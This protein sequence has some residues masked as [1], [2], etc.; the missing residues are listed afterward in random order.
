VGPRAGMDAV[1]TRRN[2]LWLLEFAILAVQAVASRYI[3]RNE[4]ARLPK[5]DC[6]KARI[7]SVHINIH[8]M[9]PPFRTA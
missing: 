1:G 3:D 2:L 8:T 9:H 4:S 5:C 7:K 6:R